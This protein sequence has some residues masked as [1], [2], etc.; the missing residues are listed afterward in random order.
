V[1]LA[2]VG[3]PHGV[4]STVSV[5]GRPYSS[6]SADSELEL[7]FDKGTAHTIQVSQLLS[8][9][10]GR[11]YR[12]EDNQIRIEGATS[13]VFVYTTENLVTFFT[14]PNNLFQTPRNGWYQ[15][16]T[17]LIVNRTGPDVID[18]A[19][20][21]R[22]VFEGWYANSHNLEGVAESSLGTV[23]ATTIVVNGSM[24]VNGRHRTEYYLNVTSRLGETEGSE[25]RPKSST[26]SVSIDRETVPVEGLLSLL[27]LKYSFAR[28]TGSSNFIGSPT[29]A[30]G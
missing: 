26:A 19:P 5:D 13:H 6:I 30:Q 9:S 7:L 28:W 29:E 21:V 15:R 18:V 10:T 22:L 17:T 12:S 23:K 27:G 20:G 4:T 16:G 24:T 3:L 8:G 2:V 11:R 14:E 25:W 1:R